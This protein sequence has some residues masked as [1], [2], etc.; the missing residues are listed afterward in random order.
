MTGRDSRDA[1][2]AF[3]IRS[4]DLV[5]SMIGKRDTFRYKLIVLTC[6]GAVALATLTLVTACERLDP[7]DPSAPPEFKRE[8]LDPPVP[9]L[10]PAPP[11][12]DPAP[13]ADAEPDPRASSEP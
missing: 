8:S 4:E 5:K 13:G 9:E 7:D 6:V 10:D 3:I 1:R 12:P 2:S 11:Q